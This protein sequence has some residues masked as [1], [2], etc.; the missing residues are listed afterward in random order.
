MD[1]DFRIKARIALD[2]QDLREGQALAATEQALSRDVDRHLSQVQAVAGT[3]GCVVNLLRGVTGALQDLAERGEHL[4]LQDVF[5]DFGRE[6]QALG[7]TELPRPLMIEGSHQPAEHRERWKEALKQDF[8]RAQA[9]EELDCGWFC[10]DSK[11]VEVPGRYVR[12]GLTCQYL[13]QDVE[14]GAPFRHFFDA[15]ADGE[16]EKHANLVMQEVNVGGEGSG[17]ER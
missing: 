3:Q 7:N 13:N 16:A 14:D 17:K 4:T 9:P 2:M 12:V 8:I 15:W 6:V 11:W 1:L 10:V 5:V